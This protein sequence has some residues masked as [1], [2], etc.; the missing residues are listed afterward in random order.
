[1]VEMEKVATF[2][3]RTFD[4]AGHLPYATEDQDRRLVDLNFILQNLYECIAAE[5]LHIG[6]VQCTKQLSKWLLLKFDMSLEQR[7]QVASVYYQ[8]ALTPGLIG[9]PFETYADMFHKLAE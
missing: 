2:P 4:Y 8:L 9:S 3:Q 6:A 7:F 5:D 1:M